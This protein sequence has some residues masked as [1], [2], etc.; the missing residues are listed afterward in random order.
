LITGGD[1]TINKDATFYLYIDGE[2]VATLDAGK[3]E[4]FSDIEID[5]N[6]SVKVKVEAEI[7][8]DNT[9]N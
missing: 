8:T 3:T 1:S 6:E 4:T 9:S 5:A 2:E 7:N